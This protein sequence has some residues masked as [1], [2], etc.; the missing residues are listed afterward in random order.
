MRF[1]S[2]DLPK[3][4]LKALEEGNLVVFAGAGVSI[5][6]PS[7]LPSFKDLAVGLA[8]GTGLSLQ[9]REPLDRF[10][11]RLVEKKSRVHEG[12][13]EQLSQPASLPN[14]LHLC[15]IRLFGEAARVRVVTTNFDNHF[16]AA[17]GKLWPIVA[18]EVFVAPALPVGGDFQGIVHLHGHLRQDAKHLVLTDRDFGRA[19]VTEGW[20]SRFLQE[21]FASYVVL[22]VGYSH[23]DPV[24]HHLARGLS[25]SQERGRFALTLSG[26]QEY[27]KYLGIRPIPYSLLKGKNSHRALGRSLERAA[28]YVAERPLEKRARIRKIL[29][30]GRRDD[31]EEHDYL[32]EALNTEEATRYFVEFAETLEWFRWA[33]EREPF[34]RLFR[35]GSESKETDSEL[36]Y[37]FARKY[38]LGSPE[39]ADAAFEWVAQKG[40][41]LGPAVCVVLAHTIFQQM[42]QE[43]EHQPI[44]SIARWIPLLL[45]SPDWKTNDLLEMLLGKLC[46]ETCDAGAAVLL[47]GHL[48]RP[49][50]TLKP[51]LLGHAIDPESG[52]G[53]EADLTTIGGEFWVRD[54][55]HRY[56][57][58]N[59]GDFAGSLVGIASA[60]LE[61]AHLLSTTAGSRPHRLSWSFTD[62]NVGSE[63]DEQ[64][65]LGVL[66]NVARDAMRGLIAKS[67]GRG[68]ALIEAWWTA[69]SILLRRLA[70]S[71]LEQCTAWSDDEK[72][73]WIL[74]RRLIGK[75][76]F[77]REVGGVIN[78]AF[79]DAS[80]V[81]K[82]R[83]VDATVAASAGY[84][85]QLLRLQ[86]ADPTFTRL[87]VE[88]SLVAPSDPFEP[89][90]AEPIPSPGDL[91]VRPAGEQVEEL[92]AYEKAYPQARNGGLLS[93]AVLDAVLKQAS[94][95]IELGRALQQRGAWDTTMW[96]SIV[97]GL[98]RDE[99]TREE[100]AIMLALVDESTPMLRGVIGEV[101]LLL[102]R[103]VQADSNPFKGELLQ[104]GL[105]IAGQAWAILD[106]THEPTQVEF[107]DWL[108]T[109]INEPGGQL[110][111]FYVRALW[112]AQKEAGEDWKGFPVD[113]RGYFDSVMRSTVWSG[114]MAR[115]RLAGSTYSMFLADP[116]WTRENLIP[117]FDWTINDRKA[118]QA[119]HGYLTWVRW[120]DDLLEQLLPFF[121]DTF[122]R[123]DKL[124]A[125]AERFCEV[126]AA[127]A[128][129]GAINPMAKAGWLRQFVQT[130]GIQ[131]RRYW[132]S[133]V[134][135]ML[136]GLKNDRKKSV[137]ERWMRDY[138]KYRLTGNPEL[139]AGEAIRM[140]QWSV[141]LEDAFAEA[142]ALI[143]RGPSPEWGNRGR[144]FRELGKSGLVGAFPNESAQ[145]LR[146]LMRSE[147]QLQRADGV[148]EMVLELKTF[149]AEEAVL[150]NI[151][152]ELCRLGDG[153]AEG[154]I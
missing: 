133:S 70:V 62:L 154:L 52:S 60:H 78:G 67:Q 29:S 26:E 40:G 148:R 28:N 116:G 55:W 104:A 20:A 54:A 102:E 35:E 15:L 37:W 123:I 132:T 95:G 43:S 124:E 63:S 77:D 5:P 76:E 94:W 66:V 92:L 74:D 122:A 17:A 139:E 149:G 125:K 32:V 45:R 1:G 110:A 120:N 105:R 47:F 103:R 16:A 81:T 12:T 27:W 69:R 112:Q 128:V 8:E 93:N 22:F 85:Y 127:V 142:V 9:K 129:H 39:H 118:K 153:Q 46:T 121:R 135:S 109:A 2:I 147:N 119:W 31:P 53:V 4:V 108:T 89:E 83:I 107:R 144:P 41:T 34:T 131:A 84:R 71:G 68:D 98:N 150:S 56:F 82:H 14:S 18:P 65:G 38:A 151:C 7:N 58:P 72:L 146:F 152:D 126:M 57:Q 134:G 91:L 99:V 79:R 87:E 30:D 50:L 21:M 42:G 6:A 73:V 143:L 75:V 114:E 141:A 51:D 106:S 136:R 111:E 19:Y 13:R 23:Q 96:K 59:I 101:I 117:L 10:L 80:A 86:R 44:R 140:I 145:L 49:V 33:Q 61:E 11:G 138:W 48:L 88:L 100:W 90:E 64:G 3:A 113:F 24:M 115:T 36:A 97:W 25:P 137:W 130:A